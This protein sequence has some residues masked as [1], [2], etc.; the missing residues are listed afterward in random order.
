MSNQP[1][2]NNYHTIP[3]KNATLLGWVPTCPKCGGSTSGWY[4]VKDSSNQA[5]ALNECEKCG[6]KF[7]YPA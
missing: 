2:P 6:Y 5:W 7:K 3:K 1:N 4:G